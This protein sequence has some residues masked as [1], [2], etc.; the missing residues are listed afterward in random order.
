MPPHNM[1]THKAEHFYYEEYYHYIS[2]YLL[3]G[4]KLLDIGC[5]MGRFTIPA[6]SA[7][8]NVT[9][10]DLKKSYFRFISKKINGKGNVEFRHETLDQSLENLPAD[11]F[12][13]IL[14]L[15][16]LYNLPDPQQNIKKLSKL[17]KPGGVLITS[18]RSLGYYLYRYAKEKNFNAA[19]LIL[20]DKHPDYN[21]QT[22][23]SLTIMCGEAGLELMRMAPIGMFSGFGSDAFSGILNPA[24]LVDEHKD[25]LFQIETNPALVE[26]FANSARYNLMIAKRS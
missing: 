6:A 15:E 4:Q 16:L 20:D 18:H 8:M 21:A 17:L 14:C 23:Q 2:P 24:K 22:V 12:D 11:Y 10:T 9:A 3:K 26:L 7:G 19:R 5:Q 25:E 1:F 13:V